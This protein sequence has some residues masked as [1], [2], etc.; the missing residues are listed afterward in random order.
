M[1]I[2]KENMAEYQQVLNEEGITLH[3]YYNTATDQT[4]Y[5]LFQHM[6]HRETFY[7]KQEM[8]E[9]IERIVDMRGK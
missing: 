7:S 3:S 6:E 8:L 4:E 1:S 2:T 5:Y 9:A